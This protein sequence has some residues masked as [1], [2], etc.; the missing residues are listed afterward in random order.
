MADKQP[1]LKITEKEFQSQVR[2]LS[3]ILHVEKYYHPFLSKW[4]EKGYPDITIIKV[5]KLIF[6]E[7]KTDKG[8]VTPA[9]QE[10]ND[11]LNQCKTIEAHI[12]RPSDFESIVSM[13][14]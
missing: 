7:L 9:Q 4:S 2:D 13:L 8:K 3:K 5:P 14:R 12:V 11:L 6:L 1:N 10:W